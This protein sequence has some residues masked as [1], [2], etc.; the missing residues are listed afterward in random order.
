MYIIESNYY[1]DQDPNKDREEE[2][3]YKIITTEKWWIED[4]SGAKVKY[5]DGRETAGDNTTA[6]QVL[7]ENMILKYKQAT[8]PKPVQDM[9]PIHSGETAKITRVSGYETK[10]DMMADMSDPRYARDEGFRQK[11]AAKLAVTNEANW[12]KGIPRG[13]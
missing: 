7:A 12:Y 10:S 1:R 2:T 4:D 6:I 13:G 8:T 3:H 5:E 11:V 9:N